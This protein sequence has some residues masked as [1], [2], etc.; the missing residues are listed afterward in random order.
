MGLKPCE[1]CGGQ[2][3]TFGKYTSCNRCRDE[4]LELLKKQKSKQRRRRSFTN[5]TG[6]RW[7]NRTR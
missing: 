1:F 5:K 3:D 4:A 6:F 2:A 7:L